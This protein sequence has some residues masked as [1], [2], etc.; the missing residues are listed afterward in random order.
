MPMSKSRFIA[1]T[2]WMV[3]S[4]F[5]AYQYVLRVMPNIM[6][7][8]LTQQFHMDAAIFGQFAGV[9][10][11]GYVGAM[12]PLGVLLDKFGPKRIMT[13]CILL[14]VVGTL[15]ILYSTHWIYPVIGRFLVGIGSSAAILG[16][17]KII[18]MTFPEKHFTRMLSISVSIGL[19]GAIYGGGPVSTLCQSLGYEDVV[20]IF[21]V[22][23]LVLA[24]ATYFIVPNMKAEHKT[25]VASDIKEVVSNVRVVATC[26]FAGLMLG[27]LEGFADVWGTAFLKQFYAFD[28]D[29]SAS[30]PSMI[31]VGMCFGGPLLSFIAEKTNTLVTII[32]S[33]MVMA[34][35]FILL[36]TGA[37]DIN[38]IGAIFVIIGICCAYQIL[39]IYK[40]S[41]YVS[42]GVAGLT[43]AFTN[44]MIMLFGYIFHTIIGSV[45]HYMGG[46]TADNALLYGLAIIPAALLLGAIG[47][48]GLFMLEKKK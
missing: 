28:N 14:T 23:G 29:V 44:M 46:V 48:I 22:M 41:T 32:M 40:A 6:L 27:P 2:V 17:F 34:I 11:I 4:I 20:K 39:A 13:L 10:Y 7:E 45:V 3:A 43:T 8:D 1:F 47:F 33:G 16:A 42:G 37:L 36:F 18:R 38:M 35:G 9:Y 15:P 24:A 21:S 30:L 25:S 31:Y 5:Y 26:I 19:L 12:L